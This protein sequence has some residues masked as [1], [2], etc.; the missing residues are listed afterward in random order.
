MNI[1]LTIFGVMMIAF[2]ISGV[3]HSCQSERIDEGTQILN[4]G[5]SR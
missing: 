1:P 4:G 3:S 5:V 2:V